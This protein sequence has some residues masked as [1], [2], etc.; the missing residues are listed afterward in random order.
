LEKR[1]ITKRQVNDLKTV[2]LL[3]V[4]AITLILSSATVF[5]AVIHVPVDQPTI[6]DALDA[7]FEGDTVLVADGTYNGEGNKNLDFQGKAITIQSE[8]GPEK[9]IIDCEG[10][11]R[12]FYFHSGEGENSKIS[13][14]SIINGNV[15]EYGGGIYF[16]SISSATPAESP[17]ITDCIISN[18][19]AGDYGGGICCWSSSPT[20]TNCIIRDNTADSGGGIMTL[21]SSAPTITDCTIENN[22]SNHNG[23]GI[24]CSSSSSSLDTTITNCNIKA[25]TGGES[26]GGISCMGSSMVITNCTISGNSAA[27]WDGGGIDCTLG[28]TLVVTNCTIDGNIAETDGGGIN[29]EKSSATIT[30]STVHGNTSA[31]TTGNGGGISFIGDDDDICTATITN[32]IIS[33]NTAI[34]DGGGIFYWGQASHNEMNIINCT[35]SNNS[36]DEDGGGVYHVFYPVD[37]KNSILWTNSPDEID[38]YQS[39][40]AVV[41]Y[42]DVQGGY[43]G[44]G[45]INADPL[46]M[47]AENGDYQLTEVSPCVDTGTNEGAPDTD[48][49]GNERPKGGGYDMGAFESEYTNQPPTISSTNPVNNAT[50]VAVDAAITATFSEAMDSSTITTD[51]FL[52]SGSSN[53]AGTV[54]Y[55]G[56]TATFT[57]AAAL[58]YTT[59]YTAT[60]TSGAKDLA[61][62]SLEADYTWS[63]TTESETEGGNGD[64]GDGGGGCFICVIRGTKF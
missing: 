42:S 43:S 12:G 8:S 11:G 54:T 14:F 29:C 18:N 9:C 60:I 59:T 45:N 61:E 22:E 32:C 7:A 23:G 1:C 40:R 51:T 13:G 63:F 58:D 27:N 34:H 62:N 20:I 28:S 46:F 47:D 57:P 52:V 21:F 41:T 24:N 31:G 64:G 3:S 44:E 26:G 19:T 50:A 35:I 37:I 38:R 56:T 10:D 6:Q 5:G 16:F 49:E 15:S 4:L 30:N 39:D 55:S 33:G 25:N 2:C 36:T 53:I 48:I 17:T